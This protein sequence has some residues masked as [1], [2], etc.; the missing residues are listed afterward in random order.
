MG[1]TLPV[2]NMV[3]IHVLKNQRDD[4]DDVENKMSSPCSILLPLRVCKPNFKV[5]RERGN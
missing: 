1:N 2:R 4:Y 5:E 3:N